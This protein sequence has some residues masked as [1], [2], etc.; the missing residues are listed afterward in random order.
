MV[1]DIQN[2]PFNKE[3]MMKDKNWLIY[4][5]I[6]FSSC[7]II[8]TG[9]LQAMGKA[10]SL[11]LFDFE[12]TFDVGT[13]DSSGAEV[14]LSDDGALRVKTGQED[15][16][17]ITLKAPSG[18][19][20]LSGFLYVAM[21][22]HNPGKE[23][24]AVSC[25]VDNN[26]WIDGRV[27]VEPG[28]SKTLKVLL[29]RNSPP[30]SVK[31]HLFGMNG[32]P[33]GYVWIWEPID[34]KKV[35]GLF[36]CVSEA[37][38][39]QIVEIDNVRAM[40]L[41]NPPSEK[42]L[43]SFFPF[44]D[45]FGQYIH[46]DWPGKTHSV[47][48]M[49]NYR[50]EESADLVGH[51][52]PAEW[53]QYGGW[54]AG[55][56]LEATGHFRVEKYQGKWWLVDPEGRL[57]WSHGIDCVGST[58]STPITDR[59]HYFS[60]L[61]DA[62]SP[63]AKFYDTS[64]WAPRGY[65]KDY[66][67]YKSYDF[68]QANLLRKYGENWQQAFAE[69]THRRLRSWGMNTIANWSDAEIYLARKTPYV[70]TI[71]S[72]GQPIQGSKGTWQKFPDPF[73]TGFEQ[74]LRERLAEEKG[75]TTDDAWCIGYFVDNELTWQDESYLARGVLMSGP[76]QPAKKVLVDELKSTY[77]TIEKLNAA[78]GSKYGSW[79][80]LLEAREE[81]DWQKAHADLVK[82]NHKIV[83]SYFSTI[84]DVIKEAAP[85]KLYL[86]CRFD[87]HFYPE[88]QKELEW[89][90][91]IAAEYCDVVSFNRYRFSA[92][93]LRLPDG[94]DKPV[95]IGEWHMGALDRGMF[96]TGLRS[97]ATQAERGDAYRNYVLGGLEN[98][99]LVG[100]H[101]FQY[102]DQAT[103]GRGDGENYQIGF[104]DICDTPYAETIA[105]CREVGYNL[106]EY[107][108]KNK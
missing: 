14:I 102:K 103:T 24:A 89:V 64:T 6:V 81:T 10:Q 56:K 78:W 30:D 58:V 105:A 95:I 45:T 2:A 4:A 54:S 40:G 36:I 15:S 92:N 66:A 59:E 50:K 51:P 77:K 7:H 16:A 20:D 38:A 79:L 27:T 52:G 80:D 69:I 100:T 34:L 33:G 22:I 62:T 44:I 35:S 104:V 1:N 99:Y 84:R 31:K 18:H 97:V 21:D 65:Y 107:R 90:L 43:K 26:G 53:N 101:W 42:E 37:K 108:L 85:E 72:G 68:G 87:F 98:P 19:W 57:F 63:L 67:S 23:D 91:R 28:Q 88:G 60:N 5:I 55:P 75:K 94:I 73:D 29:M 9:P 61:P 12:G 93:T 76:E 46:K 82:F 11:V 70:G 13:V 86:G 96:H 3:N 106:Y 41:Y 49:A 47:E 25:L 8:G 32:L 83:R 74:G 39:G 71:H 17:R 48:D